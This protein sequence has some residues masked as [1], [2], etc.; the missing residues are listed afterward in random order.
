MGDLITFDLA[1]AHG[2]VQVSATSP[3]GNLA[4]HRP[5]HNA[6]HFTVSQISSGRRIA[7][8]HTHEAA[9]RFARRVAALVPALVAGSP[10][11]DDDKVAITALV[12]KHGGWR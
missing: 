7:Y 1:T 3:I 10:L 2:L 9:T 4:V 8:L 5:R 11:S 12:G 6:D